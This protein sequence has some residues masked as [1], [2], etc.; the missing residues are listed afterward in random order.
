MDCAKNATAL[1]G[2]DDSKYMQDSSKP[3]ISQ[4]TQ[5][6]INKLLLGKLSLA[7][8]SRITGLSEQWLKNYVNTKCDLAS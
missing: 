4:R 3:I 5:E 8:I 6:L 1:L 7:E 2:K